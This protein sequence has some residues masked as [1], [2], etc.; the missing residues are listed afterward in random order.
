MPAK[1]LIIDDNRDILEMW[2]I[3]FQLE[4]FDVVTALD[5][6]D[7]YQKAESE[8]PDI[9]A[10]DINMPVLDGVRMIQKI[11]A[12]PTLSAI[13]IIA[14]TA[15]TSRQVESVKKA[16][17][18]TLLRKPVETDLL[19]ETVRQLLGSTGKLD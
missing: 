2:A 4:G 9:I 6:R 13:P 8:S 15:Y 11:R 12:H 10:T 19:I 17:A 3:L 1:I 14:I 18:N 5:G 7:G 16:G